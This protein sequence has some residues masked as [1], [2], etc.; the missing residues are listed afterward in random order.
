MI[1]DPLYHEYARV[2]PGPKFKA[3]YGLTDERASAF[4]SMLLGV[5]EKVTPQ[6]TLPLSVRDVNDEMVL[7]AALGG[8][9]DYLVT[10]D[11]DLLELRGRPELGALQIVTVVEFLEILGE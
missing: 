2:L 6:P 1:T 5:A 8:H 4:L 11:G 9:A 7:A 3:R 10:G